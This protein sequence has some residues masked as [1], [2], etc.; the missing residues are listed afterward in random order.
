MARNE[1]W[2]TFRKDTQVSCHITTIGKREKGR[3]REIDT[4]ERGR[5][6]DEMPVI[7]RY[8]QKEPFKSLHTL[9]TEILQFTD[10]TTAVGE[11]TSPHHHLHQDDN[12][13]M[14]SHL[15]CWGDT[16]NIQHTPIKWR[17][18]M[19]R[20]HPDKNEDHNLSST[21]CR[22]KLQEGPP[23]VK[24]R[25]TWGRGKY[26]Y[27]SPVTQACLYFSCDSLFFRDI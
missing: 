11:V 22:M 17:K 5:R 12:E 6:W 20:R 15:S 2:N 23:Q 19:E 27:L 1:T 18:G 10:V 4:V 7:T 26:E 13:E 9:N 24:K 14:L 16:K 21:L 3:S 8:S 25:M